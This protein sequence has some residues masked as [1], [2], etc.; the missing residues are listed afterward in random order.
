MRRLLPG[1]GALLL[2]VALLAPERALTKSC[3]GANAL[4]TRVYDITASRLSCTQARRWPEQIG[5]HATS[6]APLGLF[7]QGRQASDLR[8][9]SS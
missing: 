2:I 1:I 3:R 7:E 6:S 8:S 9:S 4:G 5:W